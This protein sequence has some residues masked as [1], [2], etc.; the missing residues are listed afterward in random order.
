MTTPNAS[1]GA[2][3]G[4]VCGLVLAA[5]L[6]AFALRDGEATE[7]ATML[8]AVLGVPVSLVGPLIG[9]HAWPVW[10]VLLAVPLNG[11]LIG[12]IVGAGAHVVGWHS[13]AVFVAIPLLWVGLFFLTAWWART[14]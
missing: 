5:G 2:L 7:L 10:L 6:G 1:S 3:I 14:H 4:A 9:S 8:G 12:A 13:R 11:A